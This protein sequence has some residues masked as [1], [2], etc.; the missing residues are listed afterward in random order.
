MDAVNTWLTRIYNATQDKTMR[1]EITSISTIY[2]SQKEISE[3]YKELDEYQPNTIDTQNTLV[4]RSIK[5][6]KGTL[7][8][9]TD[10]KNR[11]FAGYLHKLY[12]SL[13]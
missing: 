12:K 1:S 8:L 2:N 13:R 7:Y 9:S 3:L 4:K 6:L 5:R 10:P 11:C